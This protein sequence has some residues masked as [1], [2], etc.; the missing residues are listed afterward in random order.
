MAI[1][2]M[3]GKTID[4]FPKIQEIA[5]TLCALVRNDSSFESAT[6]P[7]FLPLSVKKG[8]RVFCVSPFTKL[9][10]PAIICGLRKHAPVAQWIEHR[11]PVPRVGGSSPFRCTKQIRGIPEWV[12]LLFVSRSAQEGTRRI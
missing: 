12:S 1:P 11:I 4:Y 8:G 10:K 6:N 7:N 5:T 2:Q 3:N 9:E